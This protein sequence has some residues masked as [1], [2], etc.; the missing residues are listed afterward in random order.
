MP[1]VMAALSNIGGALCSTP[2][3][4][5][6]PLLECRAVTMQRSKT[7]W[8]YLG[9][10][11][12]TK[13]SQPLVGRSSPYCGDMYGRYCCLTVQQTGQVMKQ[14]ATAGANGECKVLNISL[15][16]TACAVG[17][18]LTYSWSLMASEHAQN[19]RVTSHNS[20]VH[21]HNSWGHT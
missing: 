16:W 9:C 2:Q 17:H 4:G 10:P 11:T 15:Q 7:R 19:M 13:R 5:W 12:L 14:K 20:A 21:N 18:L 1:N 6:R 8:N 3:F